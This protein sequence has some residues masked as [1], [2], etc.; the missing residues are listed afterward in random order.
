MARVLRASELR[1]AL[2]R[3]G[4][5]AAPAL[6]CVDAGAPEAF[7]R[8]R[9][10]GALRSPFRGDLKGGP[11]ATAPLGLGDAQQLFAA[12][13]LRVGQ[14][15]LV[16]DSGEALPAARL[17]WVLRYYGCADV[18]VLDGGYSA[19]AEA[20][21]A[22]GGALGGAAGAEEGAA[23][24]LL[25]PQAQPALLADTLDVVAALEDCS[26]AGDQVLDARSPA[27]FCG[28]A[29]HGLPRGGHVPGALSVPF[30]ECLS[31]DGARRYLPREALRA[32]LQARGVDLSRP[33]IVMC[34]AGVRA[35]VLVGAL[36][37]AGAPLQGVR[38]YDGSMAAWQQE[39]PR[40]PL[41]LGTKD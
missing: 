18:A 24:P 33:T 1:A 38:L 15:A 10:P 16:Y 14:P 23:A 19:Y 3:V 31:S 27:E 39:E 12:L 2:L 13:D 22:A 25:Q 11:S 40:L 30:A 34:L 41:V 9:L 7:A 37:A 5:A 20:A 17:A 36:H 21:A 35:S 8:A 32:L 6:R 28:D 4:T 29:T 26:G